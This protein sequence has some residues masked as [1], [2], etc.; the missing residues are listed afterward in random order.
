MRA[1]LAGF[2]EDCAVKSS[3]KYIYKALVKTEDL[4]SLYFIHVLHFCLQENQ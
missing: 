4:Y 1:H 2:G 3:K